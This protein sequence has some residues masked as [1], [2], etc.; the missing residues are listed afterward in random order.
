MPIEKEEVRIAG[1]THNVT[2]SHLIQ[3]EM[4][5]LVQWYNESN[6]LHPIERASRL[7]SKF[8]NIHPFRDGN[9]RTARLLLNFSLLSASYLPVF[10]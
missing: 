6:H 3:D 7:H 8:V 1:A 5:Q 2:S 9:G 4:G 10:A